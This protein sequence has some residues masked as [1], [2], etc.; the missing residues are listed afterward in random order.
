MSG[1]KI[2]EILTLLAEAGRCA[3][4]LGEY[5]AADCK[6]DGSAVT[7]ADRA[8]ERNFAERFDH[9]ERGIFLIGEE[10]D[11]GRTDTDCAAALAADRCYVI[12]PIDGTAPYIADVP[13]WGISLGLLRRGA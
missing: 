4:T 12:D 6:S 5:P 7:A 9:P 11:P 13:L 8:I 2:D 3:L 10:T 1:W